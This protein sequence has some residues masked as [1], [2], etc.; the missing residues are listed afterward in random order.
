MM[1]AA[2]KPQDNEIQ[3]LAQLLA[4]PGYPILQRVILAEIDQFQLDLINVDPTKPNYET[5]VRAKHS[6]ALA[7]GMFY[8]RLQE[9]IAGYVNRLNEKHN[10]PQ[11]LPDVTSELLD[12]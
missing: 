6:I 9:K 1:N 2:Y 7:A 3:H 5:E 8:Q 4:S 10:Q 11:V 12:Y